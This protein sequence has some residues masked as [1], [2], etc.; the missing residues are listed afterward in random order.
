[1]AV[2]VAAA[3]GT[4]HSPKRARSST[5]RRECTSA[6]TSLSLS[7]GA[8]HHSSTRATVGNNFLSARR[9]TFV[10]NKASGAL[11]CRAQELLRLPRMG[12]PAGWVRGHA[13]YRTMGRAGA[14]QVVASRHRPPPSFVLPLK[15]PPFSSASAS[16]DKVK[17]LDYFRPLQHVSEN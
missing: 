7:L 5:A 1:M 3:A 12:T 11:R 17:S 8:G 4:A 14:V 13:A 2:T 15:A 9:S 16:S 10:W 6:G